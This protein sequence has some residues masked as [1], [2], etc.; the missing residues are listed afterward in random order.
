MTDYQVMTEYERGF[1]QGEAVA[2][3][4]RYEPLPT[5]GL[6]LNERERGYWDARLPRTAGWARCRKVPTS[7]WG[8]NK[9]IEEAS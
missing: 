8:E 2:W 3:A 5:K 1:A 9:L 6:T 4:Q 7:W